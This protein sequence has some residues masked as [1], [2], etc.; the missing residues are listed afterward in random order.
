MT[1][2]NTALANGSASAFDLGQ[3]GPS[4]LSDS[5]IAAVSGGLTPEGQMQVG[6]WTAGVGAYVVGSIAIVG[7]LGATATGVGAIGGGFLIG[8][9][10]GIFIDGAIQ[11]TAKKAN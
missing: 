7:G 9:G 6:F 2:D 1:T 10:M 11:S 8:F 5:E 4:V 3:T